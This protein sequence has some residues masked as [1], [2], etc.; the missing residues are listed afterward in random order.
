[1]REMRRVRI[2]IFPSWHDD[3]AA[4]RDHL[5]ERIDLWVGG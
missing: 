3:S 2:F 5:Q 4:I 1:V